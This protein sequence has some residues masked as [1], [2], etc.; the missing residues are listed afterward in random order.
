MITYNP[1]TGVTAETISKPQKPDELVRTI[2]G[3]IKLLGEYSSF[4]DNIIEEYYDNIFE[5]YENMDH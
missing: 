2:L 3:A 5:K 4:I 1:K